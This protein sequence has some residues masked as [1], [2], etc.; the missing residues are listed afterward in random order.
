MCESFSSDVSEPEK[1]PAIGGPK[2]SLVNVSAVNKGG[3][4]PHLGAKKGRKKGD[5]RQL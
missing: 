3:Y 5:V 1:V 2:T 4:V